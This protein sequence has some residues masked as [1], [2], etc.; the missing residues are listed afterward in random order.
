[1]DLGVGED[2]EGCYGEDVTWI[3][4]LGVNFALLL[5]EGEGGG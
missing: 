2:V 1:M 5:G 4:S 3:V